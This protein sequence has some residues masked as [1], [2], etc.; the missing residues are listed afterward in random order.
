VSVGY[1]SLSVEVLS[2]M[3]KKIENF[4]EKITDCSMFN[5]DEISM[6]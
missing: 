2:K 1:Y 6:E 3:S 5:N 4:K